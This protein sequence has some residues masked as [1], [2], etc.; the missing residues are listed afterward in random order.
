MLHI[1]VKSWL[2]SS[3]PFWLELDVIKGFVTSC[4]NKWP[5]WTS[6]FLLDNQG[7]PNSQSIVLVH[8]CLISYS[9]LI[10]MPQCWD[11]L[12]VITLNHTNSLSKMHHIQLP[13]VMLPAT[14]LLRIMLTLQIAFWYISISCF[15]SWVRKQ[16]SVSHTYHID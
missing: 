3:L 2:S 13:A 6:V 8:N 14:I 1:S 4:F 5:L 16:E 15:L 10:A 7:L 12:P 11:E 9:H